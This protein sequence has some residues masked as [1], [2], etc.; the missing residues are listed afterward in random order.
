[1][2]PPVIKIP[3]PQNA[4]HEEITKAVNAKLTPKA[5]GLVRKNREVVLSI[6]AF[7]RTRRAVAKKTGKS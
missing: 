7:E 1:M 4:K 6:F 3:V 2:R 5:T